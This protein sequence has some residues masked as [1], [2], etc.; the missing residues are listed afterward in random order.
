[1]IIMLKIRS[2]ISKKNLIFSSKKS[3]DIMA[4]LVKENMVK[5][6]STNNSKFFF[7]SLS[8]II[9]MC[10]LEIK[11][12]KLNIFKFPKLYLKKLIT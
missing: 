12:A 1:M 10:R 5:R 6:Y 4:N 7:L 8:L 3:F 2:K 9:A 11:A